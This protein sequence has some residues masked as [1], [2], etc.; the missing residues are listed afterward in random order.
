MVGRESSTPNFQND[1]DQGEIFLIESAQKG[2]L[3]SFNE[4]ISRYQDHVY[5]LT[6]RIMGEPQIA[7]DMTQETFLAAFRRLD[8]YRGGHFKAW[9]L[10][11]ATNQCYDELRRYKRKPQQ[12]IEE[13]PDAD[14][15]DG[16]AL[17]DSGQTPEEVATTRELQ[18]AIQHCIESL[19]AD[20]R[21]VIVLSDIEGFEYSE[22]AEQ[23]DINLGTVKSRLS[24][25][26]ANVRSCLQGYKELLPSAFRLWNEADAL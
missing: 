21:I 6:Y 18:E 11:I 19:S 23:A 9:L 20:Q 2:S 26:R 10:R 7:D 25:A 24:R 3:E 15:D 12:S 17:P 5:T 14:H 8:T 13:L 22:I 1:T 4:L 16:P